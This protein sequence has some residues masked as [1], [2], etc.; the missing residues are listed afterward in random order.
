MRWVRLVWRDVE[1]PALLKIPYLPSSVELGFNSRSCRG[2]RL[3]AA[4]AQN[5]PKC[6]LLWTDWT[7][8]TGLATRSFAGYSWSDQ[9][10]P[11]KSLQTSRT[12]IKSRG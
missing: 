8:K 7:S 11:G 2:H 3:K 1:C 6:A 4:A 9:P 5:A 12:R 10:S